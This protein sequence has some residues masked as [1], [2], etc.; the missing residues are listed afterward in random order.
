MA[1][2]N[3][4]NPRDLHPGNQRDLMPLQVSNNLIVTTNSTVLQGL[5]DSHIA[6]REVVNIWGWTF[7]TSSA[8]FAA[9]HLKTH[10]DGDNVLVIGAHVNG[11]LFCMLPMPVRVARG[12]G[13]KLVGIAGT[14]YNTDTH[15]F[16]LFYTTT[17]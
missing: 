7:A 6:A 9:A 17:G 16:T 3:F 2:E 15:A 5:N 4:T 10:D 12:E 11:P 1:N 13:L 8:T 14:G